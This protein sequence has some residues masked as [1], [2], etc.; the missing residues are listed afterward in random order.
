MDFMKNTEEYNY[1]RTSKQT[2]KLSVAI[3]LFKKAEAG[4]SK[5]ID[6]LQMESL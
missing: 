3:P 6:F 2:K 4:V 5:A 1:T